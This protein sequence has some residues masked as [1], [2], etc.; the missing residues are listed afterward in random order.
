[1]H[2]ARVLGLAIYAQRSGGV[3][4]PSRRLT[5]ARKGITVDSDAGKPQPGTGRV[6]APPLMEADHGKARS[7]VCQIRLIAAQRRGG[8][9]ALHLGR[10]LPGAAKDQQPHPA[11]PSRRPP[12]SRVCKA[13]H[14]P[15]I[16]RHQ[17]SVRASLSSTVM[18]V[19]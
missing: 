18:D 4:R 15:S 13:R 11:T 3:S 17:S 1:M 16:A 10:H 12:S 6:P 14:Q 8:C 5:V 2:P 19:V 7:G 9:E